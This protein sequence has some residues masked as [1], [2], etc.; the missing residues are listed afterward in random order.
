MLMTGKHHEEEVDDEDEIEETPMKYLSR[1]ESFHQAN[2]E[3]F[4]M[5]ARKALAATR[6]VERPPQTYVP[7]TLMAE[8]DLPGDLE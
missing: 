8:L 6:K 3:N 5:E 2:L 7:Q 4:E 1:D